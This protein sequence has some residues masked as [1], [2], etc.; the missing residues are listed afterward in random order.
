MSNQILPEH[1]SVVVVGAGPVGL[2]VAAQLGEMG[3]DVL[4]LER[5]ASSAII[6]RAIVLD[7]EGAR[8]LQAA[9]IS[10]RLLPLVVEG[11]GPVFYDDDGSLMARVG[12]GSREFG[13][14]KRYFIH[15]PDLEEVLKQRIREHP[16][17]SLHFNAEVIAA[18]N[19]ADGVVVTAAVEGKPRK[20]RA[21][22]VLAC[23]GARSPIREQLGIKMLG[24][25]YD[26]DWLVVDTLNDP[27]QSRNSKAFCYLSRPFMSI[28]APR[29]GRRYEFKLLPDETRDAMSSPDSVRKLMAPIRPL[30]ERDI[31]RVAVYTFQARI[32]E[33][34]SK[35]RILLLGDAAHLT[36]PFA[37]QGMN[38]GLRDTAN[39]AWKVAMAIRRQAPVS[40]L[41][42]YEAERRGP[43][44]SMI[45]LA[46][47][48]GEIIMPRSKQD[49]ALRSALFAKLDEFPG[50]R[51]FLMGMKFKPR[52]RCEDGV[53]VS[54]T[55][56]NVPGS[57]VAAM[58]PQPTVE[59]GGKPR[60]LDDVIGPRFALIVQSGAVEKFASEHLQMLWPELNPVLLS[61][62]PRPSPQSAALH[63]AVLDPEIAFPLLAHRD[64]ILLVRPDR[65]AAA[66]FWPEEAEQTV[67]AF[68]AALAF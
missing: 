2:A 42:S 21:S 55:E 66:A 64:Q 15:Q 57:L 12:E 67:A 6:P 1:V 3:V 32:A 36:P 20:I 45:Q 18:E 14:S 53:F 25:S 40:L 63:A 28:P 35:G 65:Y 59:I 46:V 27:D 61:L 30:D 62:A 22:V 58:I 60:K 17:I 19:H 44:W 49:S 23:D 54:P 34:L 9:N 48:M 7:D 16:S 11:D 56:P 31:L 29:G 41:A 51:E 50:G 43:I 39:V 37:G 38:A 52:P 13:F 33:R 4:V 10:E 47:T 26:D 5:N 68:R 24:N 8:T